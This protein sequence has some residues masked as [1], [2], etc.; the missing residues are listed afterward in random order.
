MCN[1]YIE[2]DEY[3]DSLYHQL[4]INKV[5]LDWLEDDELTIGNLSRNIILPYKGFSAFGCSFK[6]KISVLCIKS[7]HRKE[8][9]SC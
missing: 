4:L 5:F 1:D 7:S 6:V 2:Y 9:E 8:R 3:L